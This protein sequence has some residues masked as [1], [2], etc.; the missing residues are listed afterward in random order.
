MADVPTETNYRFLIASN[1]GIAVLKISK[2]D[3]KMT[4][5]K[6]ESYLKGQAVNL[7][8]S[9]TKSTLVA[10]IHGASHFVIINRETMSVSEVVWPYNRVLN[11]TGAFLCPNFHPDEL[12]FIF[13]RD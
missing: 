12:S 10:F 13:V 8:L 3:F 2:A 7:L 4:L 11:C 5:S 6:K 9:I 1:N